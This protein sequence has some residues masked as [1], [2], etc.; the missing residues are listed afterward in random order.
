[1]NSFVDRTMISHAVVILGLC[2][3]AWMWQVQPRMKQL[4]EL[5]R[6]IEENQKAKSAFTAQAVEAAV[7]RLDVAKLRLEQIE[8]SNDLASDSSRFYGLVMDLAD[9][10]D[11]QIKSLQPQASQRATTDAS[12]QVTRIDMSVEG[13]YANVAN[14]LDD[15]SELPAFTMP[16]SVQLTPTVIE[17]QPLVTANFACAVLKFSIPHNLD[18]LAGATDAHP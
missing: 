15:I 8:S 6:Q 12:A 5:D 16:I 11:V 18:S 14:F 17:Q 2:V 7:K 9:A 3:G 1:M 4:A 10:N 13:R